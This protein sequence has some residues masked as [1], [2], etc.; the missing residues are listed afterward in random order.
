MSDALTFVGLSVVSIVEYAVV[1]IVAWPLAFILLAI[2]LYAFKS[3]KIGLF[4]HGERAQTIQPPA[5]ASDS[6][7]AHRRIKSV[8][9]IPSQSHAVVID[10]MPTVRQLDGDDIK[11]L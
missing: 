8:S 3:Q 4:K 9:G 11:S 10:A 2:L 5:I 7:K 1:L 6:S